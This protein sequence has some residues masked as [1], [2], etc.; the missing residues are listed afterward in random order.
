S[1]PFAFSINSVVVP[2]TSAGEINSV[3]RMLFCVFPASLVIF[4]VNRSDDASKFLS[5]TA[6]AKFILTSKNGEQRVRLTKNMTKL[7]GN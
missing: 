4:L 6:S 5:S 3:K 2:W 7:A 1:L